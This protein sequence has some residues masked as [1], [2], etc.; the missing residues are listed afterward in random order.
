M[1]AKAKLTRMIYR[2][3][4]NKSSYINT[5]VTLLSRVQVSYKKRDYVVN[6]EKHVIYLKYKELILLL[7]DQI[8]QKCYN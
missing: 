1:D 2:V 4:W 7:S 8:N 5:L 6:P 3:F